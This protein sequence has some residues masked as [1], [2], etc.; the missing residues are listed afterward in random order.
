M[1]RRIRKYFFSGLAVVLPFILTIYVFVWFLNFSEG[2]FGKFLKPFLLNNYDFYIW[3]LGIVVLVTLI[4][5]SGFLVANY[6]GRSAHRMTE[7]LMMRI[8]LM[9]SVYPAFKEIARFLFREEDA[10][11]RPQQVVL[12]E[13]PRIGLYTLGFLTNRTPKIICDAA[14]LDLVN[15]LVPTVPNP[16]SGF[17]AMIPREN[18]TILPM[19]VE[20]AIKIVVSGGVVDPYTAF[21]TPS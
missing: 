19:T 4:L 18:V 6:F 17:I 16:L 20:D 13:W 9:G 2:I 8:P 10:A 5:C 3:G 1:L 21:Q 11:G 12:I 7:R 14:G 15:V